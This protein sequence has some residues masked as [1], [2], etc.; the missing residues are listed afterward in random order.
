MDGQEVNVR[1]ENV[2]AIKLYT[3]CGFK[4]KTRFRK[5]NGVD[6][7]SM[8]LEFIIFG[9][10]IPAGVQFYGIAHKPLMNVDCSDRLDDV[11]REKCE[12]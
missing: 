9:S 7:F 3:D 8:E 5:E 1:V 11:W 10:P 12:N 6:V 2:R 4:I